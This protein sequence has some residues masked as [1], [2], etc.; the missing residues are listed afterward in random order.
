MTKLHDKGGVDWLLK[1][2]K[3]DRDTG[4]ASSEVDLRR[5]TFGSNKVGRASI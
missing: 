2:L 1:A 5:K 3:T 4:I